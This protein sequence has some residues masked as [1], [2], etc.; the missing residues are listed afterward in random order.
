MSS[1]VLN[2]RNDE[3]HKNCKHLI[4]T[5]QI[6]GD[7]LKIFKD[8]IGDSRFVNSE[9]II[10]VHSLLIEDFKDFVIDYYKS[11]IE[12]LTEQNI[13]Q[14]TS[15]IRFTTPL[16][17][18]GLENKAIYLFTDNLDEKSKVQNYVAITRAMECIN[19]I[20]WKK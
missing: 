12:E 19:I 10:L 6:A 4:S 15:K 18:K 1:N 16:K 11:D 5:P 9:K 13:N 7:K 8:I 3:I 17:Y 2:N 20:L 14:V